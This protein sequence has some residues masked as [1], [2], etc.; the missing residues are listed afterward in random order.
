MYQQLSMVDQ[1][2]AVCASW[3]YQLGTEV[4]DMKEPK[5]LLF[6]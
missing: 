3:N 5:L 1:V 6:S 2:T 4:S